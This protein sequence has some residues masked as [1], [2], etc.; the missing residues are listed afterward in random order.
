MSLALVAGGR[1][2]AGFNKD[3]GLLS[4][5]KNTESGMEYLRGVPQPVFAIVLRAGD[6]K[7]LRFTAADAATAHVEAEGRT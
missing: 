3:T 5:L 6:G 2:L 1:T 4:V 7:E